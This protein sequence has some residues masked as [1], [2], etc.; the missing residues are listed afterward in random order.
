M[1]TMRGPGAGIGRDVAMGERAEAELSAFI[2]RRYEQRCKSEPERDLEA[3]WVAGERRQ[4]AA[5]RREDAAG[6]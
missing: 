2:S 4:E 1:D 5:R 3:V 6:W